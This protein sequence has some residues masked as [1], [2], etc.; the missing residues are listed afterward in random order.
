MYYNVGSPR[1]MS[2]EAYKQNMYSE[3]SDVWALGIILY[4][5]LF[6]KTLDAG[7]SMSEYFENMK[8]KGITFPTKISNGMKHLLDGI[9]CLDHHH[10]F[11]SIQILQ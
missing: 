7:Q 2:P 6:G 5:M 10:R 4:E 9:L 1:Y 3:K 8:I 11:T